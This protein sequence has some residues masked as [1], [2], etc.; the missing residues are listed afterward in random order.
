MNR[1]LYYW[2]AWAELLGGLLMYIGDILLYFST[3]H[4]ID[5]EREI[6]PS[7]G[8]IPTTRFFIG[9]TI[10]PMATALYLL[11]FYHLYLRV[12][13]EAKKW[14]KWSFVLFTLG[15]L[16]GCSFHTM[17]PAFG[18]VS[19]AGHPELVEELLKYASYLGDT[20][21][22]VTGLGWLLYVVLILT[23]KTSF[24]RWSI[25]FTPLITTGL[26]ELWKFLPDPIPVITWGGWLSL[27]FVIF[28]F[29]ALITCKRE[30]RAYPS[31]NYGA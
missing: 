10:G 12:K 13:P 31:I 5:I 19:K 30:E 15:M 8:S 2:T 27:I 7:M 18:I 20:F 4:F 28:Y 26:G 23:G 14:G 3:Q 11:G 16:F 22:V 25:F 9:G 24:P 21:L 29:I 1:K 17:F 6:L